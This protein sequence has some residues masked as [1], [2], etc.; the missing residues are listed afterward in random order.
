MASSNLSDFQ[1]RMDKNVTTLDRKQALG[2][3]TATPRNSKS[4]PGD[5]FDNLEKLKN[6]ISNENN[7]INPP[8]PR[9]KSSDLKML[10]MNDSEPD[11]PAPVLLGL[12]GDPISPASRKKNQLDK[13]IFGASLQKDGAVNKQSAEEN[14]VEASAPL[15]YGASNNQVNNRTN[16]TAAANAKLNFNANTGSD[17]T[18]E[19]ET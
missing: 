14:Q 6:V 3:V 5:H 4:G 19:A 8:L 15:W 9:F 7:V 10:D 18:C 13:D 16:S 12:D 1:K 17:I 11:Q 2:G